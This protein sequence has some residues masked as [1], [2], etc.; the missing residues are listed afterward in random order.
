MVTLIKS[1]QAIDGVNFENPSDIFAKLFAAI[2]HDIAAAKKIYPMT[3]F[4]LF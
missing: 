2:P 3:G 1:I 4:M